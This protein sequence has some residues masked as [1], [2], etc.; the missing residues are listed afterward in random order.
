MCG[1]VNRAY[2][3]KAYHY[4]IKKHFFVEACQAP[5][6]ANTSDFDI[7]NWPMVKGYRAWYGFTLG[8]APHQNQNYSG[9]SYYYDAGPE[10]WETE[11]SL[12]MG[13][14]E[15]SSIQYG[16][17][18]YLVSPSAGSKDLKVYAFGNVGRHVQTTWGFDV[19]FKTNL[20][21]GSGRYQDHN[22]YPNTGLWGQRKILSQALPGFYP[23]QC[24]RCGPQ[25]T[26]TR[27]D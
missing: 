23:T 16:S 1:Q 26:P 9:I 3:Q 5:V 13:R 8:R 7:V 11:R 17:K 22:S 19:E 27:R 12:T 2:K 20:C 24:G 25:C 10:S 21:I 14:F 4:K 18:P 6:I 15:H